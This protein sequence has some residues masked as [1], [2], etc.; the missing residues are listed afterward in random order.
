[1]LYLFLKAFHLAAVLTWAG[2]MLALSVA[3]AAQRA[4]G[5]LASGQ[6]LLAAIYRWDRRV[7]TPALAVVWLLGITL[8]VMG[9]WYSAPWLWVKFAIVFVLSGLHGNLSA[10]L[11]RLLAGQ[12]AQL[13]AAARWV[14][15]ITV[16]AITAVALLVIIKPWGGM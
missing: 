6:P 16:G 11:R 2:G 8:L 1:M 12:V 7:T 9:G 13:P 4:H 14:P 15:G 3:L 10:S 5:T